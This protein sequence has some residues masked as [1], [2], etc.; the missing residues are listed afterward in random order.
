MSS[1]V[2]LTD[3][4]DGSSVILNSIRMESVYGKSGDTQVATGNGVYHVRESPSEVL[5]LLVQAEEESGAETSTTNNT[6]NST[7]Q[8]GIIID[9]G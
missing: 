6:D 8:E 9:V 7:N 3:P 2:T 4:N 5:A 1:W